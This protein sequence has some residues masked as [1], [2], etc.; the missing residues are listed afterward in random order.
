MW[1]VVKDRGF[2]MD[3][4]SADTA[5]AAFNRFRI[6]DPDSLLSIRLDN[7]FLAGVARGIEETGLCN[8]QDAY[9]CIVPALSSANALP[10]L[11]VIDFVREQAKNAERLGQWATVAP[12]YLR[13]FQDSKPWGD[14]N[15]FFLRATAVLIET[16]LSVLDITHRQTRQQNQMHT[17]VEGLRTLQSQIEGELKNMNANILQR[18]AR[19]H[20]VQGRFED[21]K[22]MW[23]VFGI[24]ELGVSKHQAGEGN[25]S[26]RTAAEPVIE[27]IF[28]KPVKLSFSQSIPIDRNLYITAL[29]LQL[30]PQQKKTINPNEVIDILGWSPLHYAVI[31]PDEVASKAKIR[32][33][34]HHGAD[35][36]NPDITG[37][38]PLHHAIAITAKPRVGQSDLHSTSNMGKVMAMIRGGADINRCAR[39]GKSPLHCAAERGSSAIVGFLLRAG[40]AVDILDHFRQ[41]PL[42][43][44]AFEG[45]QLIVSALLEKGAFAGSRDQEERTPLHLSVMAGHCEIVDQLLDKMDEE[46]IMDTPGMGFGGSLM[47]ALAIGGKRYLLDTILGLV[48]DRKFVLHDDYAARAYLHAVQ[49]NKS[50]LVGAWLQI[51]GSLTM[52]QARCSRNEDG[53]NALHLAS[54]QGYYDLLTLLIPQGDVGL[55]EKTNSGDTALHLAVRKLHNR[56]DV[57]QT[58]LKAGIDIHAQNELGETVLHVAAVNGAPCS[59]VQE[60]LDAG[61]NSNVGAKT[62]SGDTALHLALRYGHQHVLKLLLDARIDVGVANELGETAI[63]VAA[64]MHDDRALDLQQLLIA[65][66][67]AAVLGA[68]CQSGDTALH[69]AVRHGKNEM[70]QE[71]LTQSRTILTHIFGVGINFNINTQNSSGDTALHM[72]A[73]SDNAPIIHKLLDAGADTRITNNTGATA[74][75]VAMKTQCWSVASELDRFTS[76]ALGLDVISQAAPAGPTRLITLKRKG[77]FLAAKHAYGYGDVLEQLR[78]V[79]TA[80]AMD[81]DL[82]GI[83]INGVVEGVRGWTTLHTATAHGHTDIVTLLLERGA[84]RFQSAEDGQVAL[85]IAAAYGYHGILKLLIEYRDVGQRGYSAEGESYDDWN[86]RHML[87][88]DVMGWNALHTAAA[89]GHCDVV[90]TLLAALARSRS[91]TS[92]SPSPRGLWFRIFGTK[93]QIPAGGDDVNIPDIL[94]SGV[95]DDRRPGH[96]V[97]STSRIRGVTA[98]HLAALHRRDNVIQ[99]LLQ[100]YPGVLSEGRESPVIVNSRLAFSVLH[101]GV[102]GGCDEVVERLLEAGSEVNIAAAALDIEYIRQMDRECLFE[103]SY[104]VMRE[105]G[106]TPL[107][108][109]AVQG[110][111]TIV[112]EL[113]NKGA[114]VNASTRSGWTALYCAA[115]GGREDVVRILEQ[116]IVGS[117]RPAGGGTRAGITSTSTAQSTTPKDR[118]DRDRDRNMGSPRHTTMAERGKWRGMGRSRS[119]S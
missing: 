5:I 15:P 107:H 83:D 79:D 119:I 59:L 48:A 27:N 8:L 57:V 37:Q 70:V 86:L 50:E 75:K 104:W 115:Q 105:D 100:Y 116:E 22:Q 78:T 92:S 24:K 23:E 96:N 85:H 55:Q 33:L 68:Q 73:V 1:T 39:N 67:S 101:A 53:L 71:I 30:D 3:S 9:L 34:L 49:W 16:L 44:A 88:A 42:H 35:P 14:T 54:A 72:A 77:L 31:L 62:K 65:G 110:Y 80:Q 4:G 64:A 47:D 89:N 12:V 113:L 82:V 21:V 19:L 90:E 25:N 108:L 51:N 112:S 45:Y 87:S 10:V 17:V 69:L 98:L 84:D 95:I 52:A 76:S 58:L 66:S 114:D 46:D 109:A 97:S 63:H 93:P 7:P 41:T 38:T 99:M 111:T 56:N 29:G 11:E 61:C 26:Q 6:E 20:E 94:I 13:L 18:F 117:S 103:S 2:K 36:N 28:I 91:G 102:L 118:H 40:A 32:E 60:L 81:P 43:L 106:Y 74:L